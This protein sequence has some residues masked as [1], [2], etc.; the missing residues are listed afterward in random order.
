MKYIRE[1]K[2]LNKC[3]DGALLIIINSISKGTKAIRLKFAWRI[4]RKFLFT[5]IVIIR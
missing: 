4:A 3:G 5:V 1:G 2:N